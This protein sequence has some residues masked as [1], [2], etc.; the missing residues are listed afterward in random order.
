MPSTHPSFKK[1]P[2]FYLDPRTVELLLDDGTL[3]RVFRYSLE[4]HSPT[5]A[6]QYL[7]D[8]ADE[9]PIRL[10]DISSV[11]LDRFLSLI[12]PAEIATPIL[13]TAAEWTSVLRLAHKWSFVALLRR[14]IREVYRLGSVVDKIAV[15]REF[16][17][18]DSNGCG[19]LSVQGTPSGLTELQDWLLPAF[20]EACTTECWLDGV[21][22]EDAERLGAG[23]VLK[24]ARIREANRKAG[25]KDLAY[26]VERAIVDA[27]LAP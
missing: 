15:A 27:G 19:G 13:T 21:S 12:Y 4:L 25:P 23:T 7:A 22:E 3:Y 1:H 17:D 18:L 10:P 8:S 24:V 2:R 20:V 5:F 26:D 14:A 9:G 16:G 11:D 6:T